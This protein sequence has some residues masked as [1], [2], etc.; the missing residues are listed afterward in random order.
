M[1]SYMITTMDNPWNPFTHF[2]EWYDWDNHKCG[3]NTCGWLAVLARTSIDLDDDSYDNDI[4][5]ASKELLELNPFGIHFKVYPNEAD[6]LIEI[7]NA[8]YYDSAQ[9]QNET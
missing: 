9:K 3:Y 4:D 8:I 7:A 1:V 5:T 6:K 2:D